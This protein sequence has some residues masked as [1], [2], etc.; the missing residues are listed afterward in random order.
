LTILGGR[1]AFHGGRALA[2]APRDGAVILV[3]GFADTTGAEATNR[4]LSEDRAREVVSFLGAQGIGP[5]RI[6]AQGYGTESAAASNLTAQG[7]S[8][9]RRVEVTVR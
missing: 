5:S 6:V 3:Q 2:A 4:A 7:R 9:N 8:R 1:L